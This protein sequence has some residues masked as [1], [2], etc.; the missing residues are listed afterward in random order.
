EP[1]VGVGLNLSKNFTVLFCMASLLF[2][3][4]Y[5][6]PSA[7]IRIPCFVAARIV[8]FMHVSAHIFLTTPF[9]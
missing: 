9:V 4:N 3:V 5:Y 8:I 1:M 2:S 6:F 7:S